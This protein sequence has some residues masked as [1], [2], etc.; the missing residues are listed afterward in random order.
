MNADSKTHK[1]KD[2]VGILLPTFDHLVVFLL[3]GVGVQGEERPRGIP[4]AGFFR[5]L[6]RR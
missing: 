3:C 6:I 4:V 2:P 5:L 1:N